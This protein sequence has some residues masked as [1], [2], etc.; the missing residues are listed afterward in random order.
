MAPPPG[1]P[2]RRTRPIKWFQ[3]L[4]HCTRK[5]EVV[6][7]VITD[8]RGLRCLWQHPNIRVGLRKFSD[9]VPP[10]VRKMD[11]K[12]RYTCGCSLH[13][14]YRLALKAV[15]DMSKVVH[16]EENGGPCPPG[17]L[18]HLRGALP[19]T[20][21]E[22]FEQALCPKQ[23]G[24]RPDARCIE[25]SCP[26][27]F[28]GLGSKLATLWCAKELDDSTTAPKVRTEAAAAA[29]TV[30]ATRAPLRCARAAR[31][32]GALPAALGAG[33]R[34]AAC[35]AGSPAATMAL[36]SGSDGGSDSASDTTALAPAS[37]TA[38]IGR[39]TLPWHPLSS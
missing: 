38:P 34:S 24:Q 9:L 17:A 28:A 15:N 11:E 21:H 16:S 20:V 12:N 23:P 33:Q 31:C 25:G 32:G 37:P 35:W 2:A 13:E 19:K 30:A 27:C 26:R 4:W 5:M 14:N 8:R 6:G 10:Q 39:L 36:D 29:A 1:A 22:F 7:F 3:P 18:C